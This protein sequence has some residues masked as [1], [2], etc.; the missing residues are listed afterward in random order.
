VIGDWDADAIDEVGAY[1]PTSASFFYLRNTNTTGSADNSFGF[2]VG[3]AGWLPLAGDWDGVGGYDTIGLYDPSSATF[4]LRNSNS[5]GG[6]DVSFGVGGANWQPVAGDWNGDGVDSIGVY[7]DGTFYLRNAN[8]TGDPNYY[9]SI[10]NAPTTNVKAIAGDW[11]GDGIY[12]VGL[13]CTTTAT[14]YLKNTNSSGAADYVFTFG[15]TNETR[16]PVAGHWANWYPTAVA[17]SYS[18]NE[19]TTLTVAASSGVL[20]NDVDPEGETKTAELVSG[21]SAAQGTLTFNSNGSFT[22]VPAANYYGTATFTYR[23]SPGAV[24]V[25]SRTATVSITVNNVND[26][27][28]LSGT[29]SFTAI[30][31]DATTNS[32]DLVSTLI[33]GKVTDPDP[34]PSQGIAVTGLASGN[35]TWQYSINAGSTWSAVGTVSDSSALLLRSTD[36]LRFVPKAQNSTTASVTFRAWD[37]TSGSAGNRV[38]AATNGGTSAFSTATATA[39]LS[40]TA[41]NDAPVLSGANGFTTITEDATT[42]SGDLV[43]TLLSGKVTDVDNGAAQGLA[44]TTLV[45]GNG[46][47]VVVQ[48]G[49]EIESVKGKVAAGR[50]GL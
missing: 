33:S 44:L 46:T 20:A 41:V 23:T 28:V 27:P 48:I 26:A 47:W 1:D 29:N 11:N 38:S 25:N 43:S 40:V 2:G 39:N 22:F 50:F 42:N 37:Q 13:Y 35:G 15:N 12:S 5:T 9:V 49:L 14:F 32:G 21:V 3:V 24:E 34:S 31:E 7:V 36:K 4:Y 19:D 45:S 10:T 16:T 8:S 18:T 6:A 30:T 17:D